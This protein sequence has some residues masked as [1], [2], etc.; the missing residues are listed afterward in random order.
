MVHERQLPLEERQ[1]ER[2]RKPLDLRHVDHVALVPRNHAHGRKLP[3]GVVGH[4]LRG[5]RTQTLQEDGADGLVDIGPAHALLHVDERNVF[6]GTHE[7][8]QLDL[9]CALEQL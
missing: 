2:L 3:L 6:S 7:P 8:P 5:E 4:V 9:S 1:A